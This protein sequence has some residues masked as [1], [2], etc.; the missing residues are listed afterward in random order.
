MNY[1]ELQ[2]LYQRL[3]PQGFTVLAFPCNQ[4]GGQEPGDAKEVS[5]YFIFEQNCIFEFRRSQTWFLV[6]L[7]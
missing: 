3:S 7:G 5:E 6:N 2:E 4:F 1:R